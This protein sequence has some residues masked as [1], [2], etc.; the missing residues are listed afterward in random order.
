M[1]FEDWSYLWTSKEGRYALVTGDKVEFASLA[2]CSIFDLWTNGLHL[3]EDNGLAKRIKERMYNSGV[4]II[5]QSELKGR[6]SSLDIIMVE[7]RKSGASLDEV[8]Y[9]LRNYEER[10]DAHLPIEQRM[11]ALENYRK[12]IEREYREYK[13]KNSSLSSEEARP[14]DS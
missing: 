11:P 8:N 13:K 1:P 6:R 7:M 14:S 12:Q 10:L 4:P 9:F 5:H 3:I 2:S